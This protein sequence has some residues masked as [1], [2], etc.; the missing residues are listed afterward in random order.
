MTTEEPVIVGVGMAFHV[1]PSKE[2]CTLTS[3]ALASV[4]FMVSVF[5]EFV[6]LVIVSGCVV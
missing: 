5:S 3:G 2:Y 6:L 4:F 1:V